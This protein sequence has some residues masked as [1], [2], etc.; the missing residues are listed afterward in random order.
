VSKKQLIHKLAETL[1]EMSE[2]E[3]EK[4]SEML[5][6]AKKRQIWNFYNEANTVP[7]NEFEAL[8]ED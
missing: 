6:E 7:L 1:N 5:N 4:M 2:D 3:L 8:I